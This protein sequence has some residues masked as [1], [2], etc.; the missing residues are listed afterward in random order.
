MT[1][2]KT[3]LRDG[4]PIIVHGEPHYSAY[5]G[6]FLPEWCFIGPTELVDNAT[7]RACQRADDRRQVADYRRARTEAKVAGKPFPEDQ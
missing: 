5:C 6:R 1:P 3:H 2:Q 4:Q 7:C